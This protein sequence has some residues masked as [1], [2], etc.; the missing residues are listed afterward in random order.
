[1]LLILKKARNNPIIYD[2]GSII[3]RFVL[4]LSLICPLG[5]VPDASAGRAVRVGVYQNVPLTFIEPGG[6]VKGFFIDILEHIAAKEDWD[7]E[8]VPAS[9]SECL[10]NLKNERI[11]LLGVIAFSNQR[12]EIF[13][14]TYENVLTEYGQIYISKKASVESILDLQDKKVA[15]MKDDM[16][17][18][19]LK[20]LLHQ[21][22]IQSR[23]VETFEYEDVLGLVANDQCDAGLVSHFYGL[24]FER[25]Y[26]IYKSSVIVSPQ[27]LYWATPKGKHKHLLD[28]LDYHLRNLKTNDN[29]IYYKKLSKW[30]G[31]QTQSVIN[32]WVLWI[33]SGLMGLILIS[34]FVSFVFRAQVKARTHE[35]FTKNKELCEEIEQRKQAEKERAVLETKLRRAQ[36]MEALGTLAGGVAHDLNNILSGIVG[37]PELILLDIPPESPLRNSI[38]TIKNSGE[39][40]ARIVEDLLTLARRG[41]AATEVVNFNQIIN[42]Y[43]KSPEFGHL[44]TYHPHV[45]LR[46]RME[47]QLLNIMGSPIHLSKTLMNLV[48]NAAEAMPNGGILTVD[49][50]NRYLDQPIRGYDDIDEGDYVVLTITD[51]GIGIAPND[52][53]RIFEPFYT[54]KVMGRSGTGLGMAVV[55]GT[56][57]DHSGYIDVRS[58]K[59]QGT[60]FTLYFPVTRQTL[61]TMP[62]KMS[63]EDLKGQGQHVLIVDDV[64]EQREIAGKMLAKLGYRVSS[65]PSGEKAVEYLEDHTVDLLV[66]DMIM[67]PGM[68][69]LDTYRKIKEI[70]PAQKAIIA[71]GFSESIRV[72]QAQ[73][74]GAGDYVKKPYTIEKIALAVKNQLG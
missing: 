20:R 53:D 19:Y 62:T 66:L 40:A 37:Y 61:E 18:L 38:L 4:F 28:R 46:T 31:L 51:T 17:F 8:Y 69:G 9:W 13:D 6:S 10:D 71:S 1:M 44:Q 3:Y 16:H 29:S 36:K 49:T 25:L 73:Q 57:R 15:V 12:A 65:V 55:W 58:E 11:D 50:R 42:D 32:Q 35:L 74:M 30:I 26:P 34:I 45:E 68:D 47:D 64:S 33:G 2:M 14:Y 27:K 67:N 56:V 48:S 7:I 5:I 72:K 24:Q 23:F 22:G 63:F 41:V 60:S 39:K 54:R 21:F 43:L 52:I 59:G 70:R